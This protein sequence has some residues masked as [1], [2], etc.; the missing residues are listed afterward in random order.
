MRAN[1]IEFVTAWENGS[2]ITEVA[3]KL[4][5]KSG[6]VQ[7]RASK[8][9]S[10]GLPLKRMKRGSNKRVNHAA[11]LEAIASCRGIPVSELTV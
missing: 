8:Y 10:L 7:A 9:R 1:S 11:I 2:S 3:E 6:S 5:M 4:G